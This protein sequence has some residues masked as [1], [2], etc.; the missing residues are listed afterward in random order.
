MEAALDRAHGAR[1]VRLLQEAYNMQS[2]SLYAVLGF[3]ARELFVV[4]AG[5]A[6]STPPPPDWQ[7]RPLTEADMQECASLHGRIHDYP[8]TNELR[9][10][11]ATGTPIVAIRGER[12]RAYMTS[13]A[14]WLANHGVGETEEDVRTLLLGAAR[15]IKDPMSFL[16][17]IRRAAL[18]RWCLEQGLRT[19]RPMMLMTIGEYRDPRGVYFP[20]V[21]Y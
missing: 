9:D 2:L 15:I 1:G 18:F 4:M 7:I 6:T 17:P 12:V 14:N 16:L 3:E 21:L 11:L 20:S 10:A 8:R 13:P 5:A 19:I